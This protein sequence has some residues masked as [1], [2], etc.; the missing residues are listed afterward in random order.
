[1]YLGV[2]TFRDT[3]SVCCRADAKFF[4][5]RILLIDGVLQL[6]LPGNDAPAATSSMLPS[7]VVGP[8]N[9]LV[10]A[11]LGRLLGDVALEEAAQLFNPLVLVGSSGSGKSQ[12]VQG[13]VRHWRRRLEPAQ[14]EYFTAADFC[15]EAQAAAD[16]A[17]EPSTAG[18]V[19]GVDGSPASAEAIGVAF[20]EASHRDADLVAVHAWSDSSDFYEPEVD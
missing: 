18:V 5:G 3:A 14:V 4:D 8:E 6:E 16:E 7:F 13:I 10:V 1:M 19:V 20:D 11:P 2:T 15:R 17:S 9:E 12:L